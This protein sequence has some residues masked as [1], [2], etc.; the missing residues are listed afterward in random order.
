MSEKYQRFEFGTKLLKGLV[1]LALPNFKAPYTM[2][3]AFLT[4]AYY[5]KCFNIT[6]IYRIEGYFRG[7]K[8][9]R[10][11]SLNN[12]YK[13]F[14]CNYFSGLKTFINTFA[15]AVLNGRNLFWRFCSI[16]ENKRKC[17]PREKKTA[18]QYPY[19]NTVIFTYKKYNST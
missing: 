12:V 17:A 14:Y 10:W 7:C 4:S 18:I 3:I 16:R 15:C 8:I 1:N 5:C 13:Y 19:T 11:F 9:S 6:W 2:L